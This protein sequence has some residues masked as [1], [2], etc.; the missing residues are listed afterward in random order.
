MQEESR[1]TIIFLVCALGLFI[2]YNFF[3]LE[4]AA[5]RRQAEAAHAAAGERSPGEHRWEDFAQELKGE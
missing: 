1:N 5:K 4:P 3:V 2:L